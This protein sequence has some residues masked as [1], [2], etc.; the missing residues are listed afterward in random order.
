[1]TLTSAAGAGTANLIASV[2][3]GIPVPFTVTVI[4]IPTSIRATSGTTLLGLRGSGIQ[5]QGSTTF[6]VTDAQGTA[7][8]GASVS[9]GQQTPNLVTPAPNPVV[10]DAN[11]DAVVAYTAGDIVGVSSVV[12]TITGTTTS[13][14]AM[15]AVRG[16]KPSASG[17]YFRCDRASLPAYASTNQVETTTCTVRLADRFG[18]RVGIP[19]QVSFAT[20]A[21][22]IAASAV[23]KAFDPTKL[24]NTEEGTATVTFSTDMGNGSGPVDVTP[25]DPDN[26]QYPWQRNAEPRRLDGSLVVNNP[27]DQLVTIIAMTRGEEAFV[28]ANHS[29][30][31]DPGEVFVDQG[32]PFVDSNDDGEYGV[33]PTSTAG[34]EWEQR[35]CGGAFDPVTNTVEDCNSYHGPNNLWDADTVIW[36]PTW[37]VFTGTGDVTT[38][39][40]FLTPPATRPLSDFSFACAD[41]ADADFTDFSVTYGPLHYAKTSVDVYAYDRWLNAPSAGTKLS[42][43]SA[44]VSNIN[45]SSFGFDAML[46]TW[47]SMGTLG[48]DF[49]WVR[50]SENSPNL[51][52]DVA[53]GDACIEQL[54]FGNFSDGAAGTVVV[55][56]TATLPKPPTY[57][58][59]DTGYG[60]DDSDGTPRADKYGFKTF[61]LPVVVTSPNGVTSLTTLQG[62]YARGS[63]L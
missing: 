42:L 43:G 25:L 16:A 3:G 26:A 30:Q 54:R 50:V 36:K 12:A 4:G 48:L 40:N 32:D 39:A 46:E 56:N 47:G 24:D 31:P 59:S 14:T 38:T 8:P 23:T 53:N 27:R 5:E 15:V 51:P 20:E 2:P 57:T 11:G 13:A 21:G 58:A 60:C 61:R 63:G 1:V 7:V 45:G 9:I 29:T 19:T 37:V 35:F 52:C 33:T 22:T 44:S 34:G 10:T 6:H 49:G 18:N 55:T 41:Y 17:F 28:D 62:Q